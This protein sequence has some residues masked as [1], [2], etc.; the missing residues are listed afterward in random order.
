MEDNIS[1]IKDR[2]DVVDVISGY[3]KLQKAGMN[4]KA[5]CPFH[6]E[7]T[8]SF[9][10][11]L[12][13]Q[14]WHCFGCSK[15]GDIFSFIQE[16]EGVEFLEALRIL[17][18]KAGVE[19]DSFNPAV[20][21]DKARLFETCETAAKFF[22]KQ[23]LSSYGK[24]ALEYLKDRGLSDTTIKE[25]RL[26]F[27]P[28][29][30][31]ALGTFLKNCG[32]SENETIE[33]GLAVRRND[34]SGAYDRFR[35]RIMFPIFD[36]N[37]QI[38][39]FTGRIFHP[40]AEVELYDAEIEQAFGNQGPVP[41]AQRNGNIGSGTLGTGEAKYINTPQ[42]KIY[43]K[44]RILYGL[45]KAKMD[46]KQADQC[47]LVEGNM[48]ALMSYQ[49]GVKNVVAS[50]GTALTSAHLTLLHRYT[51]NLSFCFDTDQAGA[52]ATRRGIGLALNQ[53]FNIKIVEMNDKDCKDPADLIKKNTDNWSNAVA[54]AKPV[55]EFYFNKA[56]VNYNP[57]SADSKKSVI[58]TLAPFLKRLTSQIEKAHWLTQLAF[59]LR[60]KEEAVEADVNLAK[61]DLEIYI[62]S[63]YLQVGL[64][65][66]QPSIDNKENKSGSLVVSSES[67]VQADPLSETLLS[68]VMKNP[69]LFKEELK[70]INTE[71]LDSETAK[72]VAGL[73]GADFTSP[74]NFLKEFREKEQS[75][76]L[77]FAYIDSQEKWKDSK[78]EELRIEFNNLINKLEERHLRTRLEKI[79]FEM[80]AGENK[81][82]KVA[83]AEEANKILN[84]L[85]E[86]QRLS[87]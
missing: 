57:E 12:E 42:T 64:V 35:S 78:D 87:I 1:K 32:F 19:L 55:L 61:D 80:R 2:L 86:I 29:D 30:W 17:A 65:N 81:E 68:L 45:N 5:R 67:L 56:K 8:P 60:V 76:K 11:S 75:Y 85:G 36:L 52:M 43:D 13:R 46:I 44:G 3:L 66:K 9:V 63:N 62:T 10:V 70:N 39:G 79:G 69:I 41:A 23:F 7:K 14:V 31:N 53:N 22:E 50:S 6:N 34:G 33:A 77:E 21:D 49:A 59:F 24:N 58:S 40:A 47:V 82:V 48:D 51:T 73:V 84:R 27:A 20:K 54:Q 74:G 71:F 18:T 15:G 16:I 37:G 38:V 72:A 26:G 28:N 25:F 83:L 4:F